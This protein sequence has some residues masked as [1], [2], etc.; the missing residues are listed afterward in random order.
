MYMYLSCNSRLVTSPKI[1]ALLQRFIFC[2]SRCVY[3]VDGKVINM[4]RITNPN[5]RLKLKQ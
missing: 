1:T 3:V 2:A 5:P 4:E